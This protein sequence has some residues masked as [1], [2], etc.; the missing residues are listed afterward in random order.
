MTVAQQI[1][2][3]EFEKLRKFIYARTGIFLGHEK[4]SLLSNRLRRRVKA[5]G[6]ESYRAYYKLLV[7][8]DDEEMTHFLSAVTTNETYFFRNERL[9]VY[10]ADEL[11][12][13][14]VKD[15]RGRGKPLSFWSAACST[16]AEAYTLAIILREKSA[17]L[18]GCDVH[19]VGSDISEN[20]LSQARAAR[21][22][23][24]A[25]SKLAPGRR[26]VHFRE[27]K[28]AKFFELRED[29]KKMVRFEHHNLRDKYTR[30]S[31]DV[32]LVRNVMMY[33]DLP[34]KRLV[35]AN[36]TQALKPGGYLI[37]GDVDPIRDGGGLRDDCT[38]EYVR[39]SLYRKPA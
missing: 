36:V 9:W 6:L 10:I 16:G 22:D 4:V 21:Y 11:I 30:M 23:D 1:P 5:L 18:A 33:F 12:P 26:R 24:Y 13:G 37:I 38:L 31:F 29:T 25:L 19:I 3:A 2:A 27:D 15:G 28:D 14:L 35:L 34:M 39:P 32:V 17:M 7:A 20:V 8:G